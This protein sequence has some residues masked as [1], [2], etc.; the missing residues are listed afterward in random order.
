MLKVKL[1]PIFET[2][3]KVR[4]DALSGDFNCTFKCFKLSEI[5]ALS[6]RAAAEGADAPGGSYLDFLRQVLSTWK[7]D[8][9]ALV[10]PEGRNDFTPENLQLM[11]D[12]P[13]VADALMTAFHR[14]HREATAKN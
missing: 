5:D 1:N 8:D 11:C 2:L 4:T 13:G 9:L 3:V 12:L 7:A 14:G 6:L 10:L